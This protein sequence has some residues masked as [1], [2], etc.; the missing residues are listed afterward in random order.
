[1]KAH[2]VSLGCPKNLT[3]TER[4]M[5]QLAQEGYDFTDNPKE[6]DLILVNTC[7]FL[8]SAKDE[9]L[10]TVRRLAEFKRRGR[11]RYLIVAGCLPQRYKTE[12]NALLPEADA[13]IGTPGKFEE[14]G[15]QSAE[16]RTQGIIKATPPWFAYVKI[17]EG[18][19]NRCAYCVIPKIRGKL[20]HRSPEAILKEVKFL[21]QVGVKEIIYIAQDTTAYPYLAIL[22]KKTAK[23]KN[24]EWIRIMYAYPSHIT[25]ELLKVMA[26]E[27]KIVKYLDLPIQH[28]SDKILEL[29]GRRY[30]RHDLENLIIKIRRIV[31][32]IVLRTS[33]IA[34]FPGESETEFAE[35][36][37]FI[38]KVKFHHLG[39]FTYSREAGTPANKMRGQVSARLK[40][41][42]RD[43]LMR[44]QA[45]I[46]REINKDMIG[47]IITTIIEG[48]TRGG[49]SGRACFDAPE[50]DGA[51]LVRTKKFLK[52]GEIVNVR[53][54][55]ARTYDLIG[56]L[57]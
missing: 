8:T 31:P 54:T 2:I 38:K 51:V 27:R 15:S 41:E 10:Q 7:A 40:L 21:A 48:S 52:P 49:F 19:D 6:A 11:C 44:L 13:F 33:V 1:M 50:I 32:G 30:K 4:L 12:C 29:M 45:G 23:I 46:A 35:L 43:K 5:G 55:D 56:C 28:A 17:S 20:R 37:A 39:V 24:I 34:G 14:H 42:R 36:M 18:C 57:T 9:S 16:H 47:Q 53:V 3:D 22:L 25:D 26:E